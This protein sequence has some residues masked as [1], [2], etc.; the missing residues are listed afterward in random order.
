MRSIKLATI[1][2]FLATLTGC[3]TL[4][5]NST[6]PTVSPGSVLGTDLIAAASNLDQAIAI[7][8]LPKGDPAD[9]CLHGVLQQV[10]LESA[11]GVPSPASFEAAR[12]G[13]VSEGSIVYIKVAQ[14]KNLKTVGITPECYALLGK[15][16]VDGLKA[17]VGLAPLLLK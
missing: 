10:G 5:T 6:G 11:P 12:K 7:G 16:Q 3:G 15:L 1:I 9:V 8:V 14:L 17:G 13:L 2:A 4:I